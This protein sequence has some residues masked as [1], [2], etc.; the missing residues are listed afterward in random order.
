MPTPQQTPQGRAATSASRQTNG[1]LH[2]SLP[3]RPGP[4]LASRHPSVLRRSRSLLALLSL[5]HSFVRRSSPALGTHRSNTLRPCRSRCRPTRPL[6]RG[7]ALRPEHRGHRNSQ[8]NSSNSHPLHGTFRAAGRTTHSVY[9]AN[10]P[11][12]LQRHSSFW[13]AGPHAPRERISEAS[14][15]RLQAMRHP[16]GKIVF[17]PLRTGT[18][19]RSQPYNR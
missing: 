6:L 16:P 18:F 5:L 12:S 19:G 15:A 4:P 11:L 8:H 14:C 7:P 3:P 13:F 2:R 10:L 1:N 9:G 17:F